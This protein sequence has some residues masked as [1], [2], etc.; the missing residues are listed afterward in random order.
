VIYYKT[1]N[2][3]GWRIAAAAA[4]EIV[5]TKI[6]HGK[7]LLQQQRMESRSSCSGVKSAVVV[8]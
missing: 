2:E 1:C 7:N 6:S 5:A 4:E 8:T 3:F